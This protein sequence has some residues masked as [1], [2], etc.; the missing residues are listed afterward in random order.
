MARA[1][2][3]KKLFNSFCSRDDRGFREAAD[4]IIQ[5]ERKKHHPVVANE[6]YE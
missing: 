2:L 3:L 1:D 4:E 5:E 6:L